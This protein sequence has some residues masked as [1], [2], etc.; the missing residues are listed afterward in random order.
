MVS[1]TSHRNKI[2]LPKQ[3]QIFDMLHHLNATLRRPCC[4]IVEC[5]WLLNM[6]A[7]K[8]GTITQRWV[9]AEGYQIILR[10]VIERTHSLLVVCVWEREIWPGF[11]VQIYFCCKEKRL[12]T[13]KT[14]SE[15]AVSFCC[16]KT[17]I[18][19]LVP[20][21]MHWCSDD[22]PAVKVEFLSGKPQKNQVQPFCL[23]VHLRNYADHITL[24]SVWLHIM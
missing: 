4:L 24:L 18:L 17:I 16:W 19:K 23:L 7:V 8:A 2:K 21:K 12:L 20:V 5:C 6:F 9:T 15:S 3:D 10:Q 14:R 22:D 13:K 1:E 11:G